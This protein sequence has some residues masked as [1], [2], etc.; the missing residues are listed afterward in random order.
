[1]EKGKP[2]ILIRNKKC[3]RNKFFICIGDRCSSWGRNWKRH[4]FNKENNCYRCG[5]SKED[6]K[7]Q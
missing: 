2:N 6:A 7:N 4:W 5:I 3:S 1:M